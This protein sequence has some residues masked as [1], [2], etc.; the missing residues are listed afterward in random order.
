MQPELQQKGMEEVVQGLQPGTLQICMHQSLLL[1]TKGAGVGSILEPCQIQSCGDG[2][3]E[4]PA[5]E[6]PGGLQVQEVQTCPPE[7]LAPTLI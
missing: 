6:I 5:A 1:F 7:T 3:L 2:S 4:E